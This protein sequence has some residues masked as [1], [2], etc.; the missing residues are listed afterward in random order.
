MKLDDSEIEDEAGND[1][2][3]ESDPLFG[4]IVP[5]LQPDG[6]VIFDL[7]WAGI[8]LHQK[9]GIEGLVGGEGFVNADTFYRWMQQA[10][11]SA[12]PDWFGVELRLYE[13]WNLVPIDEDFCYAT[14]RT[15][16]VKD[17]LKTRAVDMFCLRHV[18]WKEN[19]GHHR[20]FNC[21]RTRSYCEAAHIKQYPGTPVTPEIMKGVSGDGLKLTGILPGHKEESVLDW[22]TP[23]MA[24]AL[25]QV[26]VFQVAG[27]QN[28]HLWECGAG[29]RVD[30]F[31]QAERERLLKVDRYY[32][33]EMMLSDSLVQAGLLRR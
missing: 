30:Q 27:V 7:G 12:L 23:D 13:C 5:G 1:L 28:I 33:G 3:E 32:G 17:A 8:W 2:P 25:Q 10:S 11:G 9:L 15:E 18:A 22:P 20:A 16:P 26:T 14:W 31:S 29:V 6:K 19:E 24:N 21:A 4:G